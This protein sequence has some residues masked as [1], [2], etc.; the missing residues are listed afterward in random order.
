MAKVNADDL[1]IDRLKEVL[2]YDHETGDFIWLV[3]RGRNAPAGTKASQSVNSGGYRHIHVDGVS[4]KAHRLAWFYVY[5]VWPKLGLD[6]IN[7][8]KHDNRV[9]TL[10]EATRQQNRLNSRK[11]RTSHKKSKYHGVVFFNVGGRTGWR[12]KFG[13][14]HSK[15]YAT[16]EEAHEFYL[17]ELRKFS[18]NHPLPQHPSYGEL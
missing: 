18:E 1:T 6:H 11:W 4:Y 5:G 7:G 10:R 13:T 14:K 16:E 17:N 3:T 9:A 12:G 8:V 15:I 2:S